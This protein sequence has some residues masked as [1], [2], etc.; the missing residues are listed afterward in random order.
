[1]LGRGIA[2]AVAAAASWLLTPAA[3]AD[4]V[5]PPADRFDTVVIDAGHGGEDEG[6]RGPA[7]HVEKTLVLD[8]ARMLSSRLRAHGL[9][10]VLT[11][12]DDTFV[13]LETRTAIANDAR[14]D[15]FVSIHANAAPEAEIRGTETF[16]L[17]LE[18]SDEYARRVAMRENAAFPE[19]S[20]PAGLVD[21]PLVAI[22]GDMIA[23]EHSRESNAF[24]R[25][26]QAQLGRIDPDRSRGVK[27][28]PFVVLMGIQ[29]PASLVEVGFITN[30]GDERELHSRRGRERIVSALARAVLE[31]GRRTDVRRGVGLRTP[32][33]AGP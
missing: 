4:A 29:M 3:L 31:F 19:A 18:A 13:P 20:P 22:L 5:S 10:V 11:R 6:A 17:S 12:R 27:Q 26:A 7:G 8:L 25:M 32:S 23:N 16:F 14:G 24:A 1:V 15:L 28:A 33:R 21:D 9:R 30:R 2:T